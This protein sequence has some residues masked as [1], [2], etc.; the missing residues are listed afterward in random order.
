MTMTKRKKK[1][2]RKKTWKYMVGLIYIFFAVLMF[3]VLCVVVKIFSA[4]RPPR[5]MEASSYVLCA[6]SFTAFALLD[7]PSVIG[8][9]FSQQEMP[10]PLYTQ[11]RAC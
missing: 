5:H 9:A 2:E 6:D 4:T 11:P 1:T 8:A 3:L 7:C 10:Y